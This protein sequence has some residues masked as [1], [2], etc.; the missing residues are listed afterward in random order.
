MIAGRQTYTIKPLNWERGAPDRYDDSCRLAW[1]AK[2]PF[3]YYNVTLESE[4]DDGTWERKPCRMEWCFDEYYDEGSQEAK[5]TAQAKRLA[6]E[7][8]RERL[9]RA[10][11]IAGE[12][13]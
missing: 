4:Y 12:T 1:S 2:T 11:C 8:W 9:G 5:N 3:G 6:E 13:L 7:H 10:L